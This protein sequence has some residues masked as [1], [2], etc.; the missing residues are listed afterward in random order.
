M[1]LAMQL[2]R[3]AAMIALCAAYLAAQAADE[4]SARIDLTQGVPIVQ[5]RIDG[6]GPFTFVID[7]G[8]NC[9]AIVA[10]RVAKR[11][12]LTRRGLTNITDLGGH[13][14]HALDL[15]E[16]DALSVAATEFRAV[17][18]VVTDLPDGDSV[19]DGIL[20]FS[21]FRNKML[22]LDYPHHK[23]MLD[24]GSLAGA[25]EAHVLPIRMPN[26]VPLVEI[27]IAGGKSEA[28]IDS[29]GVGLSVP[30]AMADKIPFEGS[31]ETVAY[32]RTQVSSFELRGAVLDGAVDLAGFRF[33]RPWVELNPVFPA[34]NIGSDAMRDFVVTFDQRSKLVRFSAAGKVH[35]LV[36][37]KDRAS[38]TP[39]DELVGTV[40]QRER[41]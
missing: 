33:E 23:L 31:V 28:G 15:V 12:G 1:I 18:A 8:T 7:T 17:P 16:L 40:V 39:L 34:V 37:P 10:P 35:A 4:H 26:G 41:Y 36:K 21:L 27:A 5:V 24:E 30:S 11:L 6:Q 3:A 32:G 20:G 25:S 22:T 9:Q 19:L 13:A 14:T 38:A 29:G 2:L